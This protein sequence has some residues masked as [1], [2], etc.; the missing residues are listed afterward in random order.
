MKIQQ[1]FGSIITAILLSA[2]VAQAQMARPGHVAPKPRLNSNGPSLKDGLTMQKGR[3]I[4]TE[5]GVTNP[6]TA[7]KKLLNGTIITPAGVVT[8]TDGTATQIKEGDH[9]SLTGRLT[10]HASIV[11]ADSLAKLQ[12]YDAKYPGKRAKAAAEAE[13]KAKVAAKIKEKREKD[14][15][16]RNKK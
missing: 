16:K 10:T 7:D 9:V 1:L 8:G 15:A 14:A 6:L 13:R 5:L 11:E 2:T 4:L 12:L 3:I